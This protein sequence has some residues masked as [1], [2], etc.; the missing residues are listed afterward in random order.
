MNKDDKAT[1]ESSQEEI[2]TPQPVSINATSEPQPTDT[3]GIISI[4]CAFMAPPPIGFIV[5]L[6]GTSKAKREN[7]PATLSR[8]GWILNLVIDVIILIIFVFALLFGLFI[9]DTV[10]TEIENDARQ[11]RRDEARNLLENPEQVVGREF[12]KGAIADMGGLE[13]SIRNADLEYIPENEFDRPDSGKK[14]IILEIAVKNNRERL[15]NLSSFSF[16]VEV[17][18][19]LIRGSTYLVPSNR[20]ESN[21]L[22][23][24]QSQVG[25]IIYEVPVDAS[26]MKLVFEDFVVDAQGSREVL[27]KLAF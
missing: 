18:S 21:N 23:L 2:S 25:Q 6:V 4:I 10:T 17:D 20:F 7:R 13:V 15:I 19:K 22:G 5:G 12:N 3:L 9:S 8:I 11:Q 1:L 24:G 27:Y 16:P 26:N 14:F